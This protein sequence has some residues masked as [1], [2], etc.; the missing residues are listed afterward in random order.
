LSSFSHSIVG[1]PWSADTVKAGLPSLLAELKLDENSHGGRPEWRRT[2][3][4]SFLW[5]F[6]A[7]SG[8]SGVADPS[9]VKMTMPRPITSAVQVR[10]TSSLRHFILNEF[11]TKTPTTFNL[12]RQARDKH[13]LGKALDKSDPFS[14]NRPSRCQTRVVLR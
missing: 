6:L 5:K 13:S 14:C 4:A 10:K 1:K 3:Y 8:G 2:L 11:Y 12:P 9:S 7:L